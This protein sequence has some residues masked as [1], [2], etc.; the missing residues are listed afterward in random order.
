MIFSK[1]N[2]HSKILLTELFF[3]WEFYSNS[4]F[5][6]KPYFTPSPHQ[7]LL[8]FRTHMFEESYYIQFSKMLAT[9]GFQFENKYRKSTK[10]QISNE[11]CK[12]IEY[13]ITTES[14]EITETKEK[15]GL[16]AHSKSYYFIESHILS[17]FSSELTRMQ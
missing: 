4:E 14:S 1:N 9:T 13:W 5:C 7:I 3:N 6:L 8:P 17:Q 15:I 12:T 10:S 11:W 16:R 2:T